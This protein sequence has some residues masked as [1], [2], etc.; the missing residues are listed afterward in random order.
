LL[1]YLPARADIRIA[2]SIASLI[3]CAVIMIGIRA[4]QLPVQK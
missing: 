3:L 2:P 1:N 4:D